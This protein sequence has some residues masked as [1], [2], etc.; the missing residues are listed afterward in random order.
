M[1]TNPAPADLE[2]VR[3]FVNTWDAE[4]D[5][6]AVPDAAALTEWLPRESPLGA[7]ERGPA[8]EA[9]RG[10]GGGASAADVRKAHAVRDALRATLL[11]HHGE[12][13][14]TEAPDVLC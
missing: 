11:S 8:G 13:L 1:A 14:D 4:D 6:D 3:R 10:E 5:T 9:W 12:P 2:R 7:G